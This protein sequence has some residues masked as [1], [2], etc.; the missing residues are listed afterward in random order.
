M[1]EPTASGLDLFHSTLWMFSYQAVALSGFEAYAATSPRGRSDVETAELARL[2]ARLAEAGGARVVVQRQARHE[3][4]DTFSVDSGSRR[5]LFVFAPA[6][7]RAF[8]DLPERDASKGLADYRMLVRKLPLELFAER[9]TFP[10]DLF[11]KQEVETYLDNLD[12]AVG[13]HLGEMGDAGTFDVFDFARRAGHRIALACWLGPE[14]PVDALIPDM[15]V[16]DGAEAFVYPERM[17]ANLESTGGL[18]FSGQMLLDHVLHEIAQPLRL[19]RVEFDT[20]RTET[21][22]AAVACLGWP[23]WKIP[24]VDLV[25]RDGDPF[26]QKIIEI[27]LANVFEMPP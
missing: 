13:E 26:E 4:G 14:A 19:D 12:F 22:G 25:W 2:E 27:E 6:T 8:Y 9:R 24:G 21:F 20:L 16:L 3:L 5:Y 15:D 17:L 18:V 1:R 10:H 11:G 23:R 7:L